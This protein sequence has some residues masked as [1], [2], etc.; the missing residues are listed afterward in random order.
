MTLE[1]FDRWQFSECPHEC[2]HSR[3]GK[4]M[5]MLTV[6]CPDCLRERIQA[7]REDERQHMVRR[8]MCWLKQSETWHIESE[9]SDDA[10]QEADGPA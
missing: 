5:K 6:G 9:A 1:P 2:P 4:V 10:S 3:P 7:E 8:L